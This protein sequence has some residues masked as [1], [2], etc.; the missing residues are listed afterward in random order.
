MCMDDFVRILQAALSDL[1]HQAEYQ[2]CT[3]TAEN[4]QLPSRG[5][6]LTEK[7]LSRAR[8]FKVTSSISATELMCILSL[9]TCT[10]KKSVL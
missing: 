6:S 4:R 5:T 7:S 1:S 2:G 10:I 8:E 3:A 9:C